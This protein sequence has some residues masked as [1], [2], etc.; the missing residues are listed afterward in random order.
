MLDKLHFKDVKHIVMDKADFTVIMNRKTKEGWNVI[1]VPR[2]YSISDWSYHT[3]D[4]DDDAY[5]FYRARMESFGFRP[6][7]VLTE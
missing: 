5:E 1:M 7:Y 2:K 6:F 3:Y 4:N